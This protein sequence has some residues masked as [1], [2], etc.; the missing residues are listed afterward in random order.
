MYV[1]KTFS[2]HREKEKKE[3]ENRIEG[4]NVGVGH[5]MIVPRWRHVR[6]LSNEYLEASLQSQVTV[7]SFV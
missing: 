4:R 6:A 5:T 1:Y 7:E 2:F 3:E